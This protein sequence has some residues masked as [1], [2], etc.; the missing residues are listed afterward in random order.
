MLHYHG[1][2][3]HTNERVVMSLWVYFILFL[4]FVP[5]QII[6]LLI[7]ECTEFWSFIMSLLVDHSDHRN[8]CYCISIVDILIVYKYL[9]SD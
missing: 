9:I 4:D 5:G 1:L 3:F 8:R 6:C 2:W 7:I